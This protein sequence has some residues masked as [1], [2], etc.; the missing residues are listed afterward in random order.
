VA[1]HT[2]TVNDL[3][4]PVFVQDGNGA[5]KPVQ[6]CPASTG[7]TEAACFWKHP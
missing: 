4:W 6:S 2:L 1:E 5:R 3:I 7:E